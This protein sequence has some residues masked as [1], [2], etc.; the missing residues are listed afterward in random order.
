MNYK[1]EQAKNG[2]VYWLMEWEGRSHFDLMKAI[3][4][5]FANLVKSNDDLW[6]NEATFLKDSQFFHLVN[7]DLFGN[8]LIVEKQEYEPMVENLIIEIS[9]EMNRFKGLSTEVIKGE[10]TKRI[11]E[12][13]LTFEQAIEFEKSK[14][15]VGEE[16]YQG[17]ISDSV[18]TSSIVDRV[19]GI[20]D[21]TI[22]DSPKP[23]LIGVKKWPER[24]NPF[25]SFVRHWWYG[26]FGGKR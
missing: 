25:S 26:C 4:K 16:V 22:S 2:T 19:F 5:R 3:I 11:P 17:I 15:L 23:Q 21:N 24:S 10:L 1:K 20:D 7:D 14:G 18:Q 6:F 13:D 9:K 8:L 12:P